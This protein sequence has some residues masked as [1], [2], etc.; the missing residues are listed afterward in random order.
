MN[1][2]GFFWLGVNVW[3]KL[4]VSLAFC[5]LMILLIPTLGFD[6]TEDLKHTLT[7]ISIFIITFSIIYLIYMGT[8][9]KLRIKRRGFW[10]AGLLNVVL[11]LFIGY[12][13]YPIIGFAVALLYAVVAFKIAS[14]KIDGIL[15]AS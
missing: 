2:K 5:V 10:I 7:A 14:H 3:V 15:E 11:G 8:C 4:S 12:L 1:K 13:T 9:R 6:N